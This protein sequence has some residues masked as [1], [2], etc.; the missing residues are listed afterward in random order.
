VRICWNDEYYKGMMNIGTRPT[1]SDDFKT[2]LEVNIFNFNQ[3]IYNQEI[4]IEF[5]QKIR[6]EKKFNGLDELIKQLNKD[7]DLVSEILSSF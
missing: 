5:I 1:L 3:D 7:K 2:S 6:D 4:E